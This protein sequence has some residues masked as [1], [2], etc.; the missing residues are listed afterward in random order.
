MHTVNKRKVFEKYLQSFMVADV[1]WEGPQMT[2][3]ITQ[4]ISVL[5]YLLS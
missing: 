2:D 5:K 3:T 1:F 4:G